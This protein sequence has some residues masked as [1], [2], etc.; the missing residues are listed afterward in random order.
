MKNESLHVRT[1]WS[2]IDRFL[3]KRKQQQQS[4]TQW[5]NA[6]RKLNCRLQFTC[7]RWRHLQ[8]RLRIRR[9][10]ASL[11]FRNLWCRTF[12]NPH[13]FSFSLE[14]IYYWRQKFCTTFWHKLQLA[15]YHCKAPRKSHEPLKNIFCRSRSIHMRLSWNQNAML[16]HNIAHKSHR[17]NKLQSHRLS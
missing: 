7:H 9:Q 12:P 2:D 1:N 5:S 10:L 6:H 15:W 8:K 16:L 13:L 4:D 14:I 11:K 17:M 3:I